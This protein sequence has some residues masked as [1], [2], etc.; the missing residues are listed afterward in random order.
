MADSTIN[1]GA[2]GLNLGSAIQQVKKGQLTYA[3]NAVVENFDGQQV[4]Y[5]TEPANSFCHAFPEGY[6]V[7]GHRAIAEIGKTVF[8]LHNP[9]SG[10]SEVGFGLHDSCLYQTYINARCLNFS[11]QHPI[12]DVVVKIT[13]CSVEVYWTDGHN[14]RR[15]LDLN[16]K[17]LL[18]I[19][20][21]GGCTPTA[22]GE[23][24]CNKLNVQPRYAIPTLQIEAVDSDGDLTAGTYQFGIQYSN[25]QS[26]AY[27]SLHS[28][29]NP[30]PIHDPSRIGLEYNY[31]VGRA[32]RL[33]IDN[34]DQGGFY[35]YYNLVVIKTVNDISTPYLVGTYPIRARREEYTYTGANKE[36]LRLSPQD[37]FEKFPYYEKAEGLTSVQ[38]VL[39]WK[40]LTTA[41]RL[42]YQHIWN[43]VK[44]EWEA[45][46]IPASEGYRS[47]ENSASFR[48]F[49]RDEV[50]ALEGCFLLRNG[51]QTDRFHMPGRPAT[52]FDLEEVV[53]EDVLSEEEPCQESSTSAP[54]YKVVNTA[55]VTEEILGPFDSCFKGPYLRGEMGYYQSE[56]LYPCNEEVWG[57]LA[58]KPIRHHRMPDSSLTHIYE[59]EHIHP[60]GIRI[61]VGQIR[62][63]IDQ[64]DLSEEEKAAIVGFKIL[65]ANRANHKSVV[66]R[67]LLF[68][69]GEY[70]RKGEK[71]LYPNY[72]YNDLR[73]DPFLSSAATRDDSG[74][75]P[76]LRLEG[77]GEESRSR[78][79]FHSP[80]THFY[81]PYLGTVLK[82]ETAEYGQSEGQFAEVLGHAR[83]KFATAA[84]FGVATGFGVLAAFIPV[85]VMIGLSSG[86][87][88]AGPSAGIA[89]FQLTREL[90]ERAI[91]RRNFAYQYN[92]VG[93]YNQWAP[94][95]EGSRQRRL[96][97]AS[98][99]QPGIVAV[100]ESAPLNNFQRESSVYLRTQ[101]PLPFPHEIQGVPQDQSRFTLA[102]IGCD[103]GVHRRDISA[104]YASIKRSLPDQYGDIYSYES[105]DTGTQVIFSRHS[106]RF[107]SVFGGDVFINR[108]GLKR[109]LP[110][111][112]DH[113]VNLPDDSDV[114]Y[115]EIG[116]VAY[117][118][119]WFSTDVKSAETPGGGF[120]SGLK[121]AMSVKINNFDCRRDKFFYQD[122]KIYLFAYG[123]PYF[124]CESEVNVDLRSAY[125][126]AEG[127]FYP[128]VGEGIPAHWLQE[129]N[130]SIQ[131]DNTFHY[132]RTYSKQ[133][134]ENY[135]SFLPQDYSREQCQERFPFRAVYSEQQKDLTDYK[136][137]NWLV[138]R[139]ASRF[140]FPQN[141]G[142]LVSL[143]G[144]ENK[145]ILARF[146]SKSL[147]YNTM[148][149]IDTSSPLAAYMGNDT[150][151]RSAPPV[152]FADTA[153]GYAG[154]QHRLLLKTAR[155]HLSCDTQRG[156]V[157][158]Y[159]G[160]NVQ[161]IGGGLG[162][163]FSEH[164]P[165]QL[166]KA[167]PEVSCDN[168]FAGAGLH[169][170]VD[171]LFNRILLTKLD[172]SPLV[173][174][175]HKE[176]RYLV[177]G[178]EVTLGDPRYFK[179]HS[180]TL[181]FDF[182]NGSWISFHSYHPKFYVGDALRF[183]SSE[184]DGLWSHLEDKSRF[185]SF[186]GKVAPYALEYPFSY[187]YHDEI[188][189][190]VKDYSKVYKYDAD[191]LF[192]AVDDVFF[193]KAILYNDQQ[194]TG[195][196]QLDPKPLHNMQ[197]R[198]LYPK[199]NGDSKTILYTKSDSFYNY[200]TFWGLV[201][202]KKQP[203]FLRNPALPLS[204][205]K[206]VN[207]ANMDY[208]KRAF[209]K[210]PLRAKDLKIRH[211]L[212]NQ[213]EYKIISQFIV[214]PT[215]PSLK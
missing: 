149:R 130:V 184:G 159:S 165:F 62:D 103:L 114:F 100:G 94:I 210:E 144:L 9:D 142:K 71:Y 87:A 46:K 128:R 190:S 196:L 155:G 124:W 102:E 66:A 67:G 30:V 140:D 80:D 106:D 173:P 45:W 121:A 5:Q 161:E 14:P 152:E 187:S 139:P 163:F 48:S 133:N 150:L 34:L 112:L 40:G 175:V 147:L 104:F 204:F 116:N 81:Q 211:I 1:Y 68:N 183:W 177:E 134:K 203:L 95:P 194:S 64:S 17:P 6:E 39:V 136:R 97:L 41:P 185:L 193:N 169:G 126:G 13:N 83:Y 186:Y 7:I 98:Y 195:I 91:P 191:L 22:T 129:K 153:L 164:L 125:N 167:F 131:R 174:M 206:E 63:L 182:D 43:K 59:G 200:N 145:A 19:A 199:Y 78:F 38:D 79:T 138:Y 76:E 120:F 21:G 101:G 212:D 73:A 143:D 198:L 56:R 36:E 88:F 86:T 24:D 61:D 52:A 127:D 178:R 205:D 2:I 90:I 132:N 151:F 53:S 188:L 99:V 85:M 33:V 60:L 16:E 162:A 110:F 207:Q 180:F 170:V 15:F 57:E 28:I 69:A 12:H 137:N 44:V 122:G 75:N 109:K 118:T 117:P 26:E 72:P 189:Q 157:F 156:K 168:H 20:S 148:L 172:Y 146:E 18:T 179:N 113:R 107:V 111:F 51:G 82:L 77:F 154:T 192:T 74:S 49:A 32:I 47:P 11:L 58:G 171:G 92:S 158:L 29:T 209:K 42:S 108:F 202:D 96:S 208:S 119:Y 141:F 214:A 54:R 197:A 37:V 166:K 25:A 160:S 55:K 10:D 4:S 35:D 50:Y 213:T 135:F 115:D 89:A 93:R 27:T 70:E 201:K 181:S 31:S 123:I 8:F 215:Q 65:R 176:G 105:V 84:S 3:L 23:I